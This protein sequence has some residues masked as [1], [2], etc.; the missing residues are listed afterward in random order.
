[1][2]WPFTLTESALEW[3]VQLLWGVDSALRCPHVSGTSCYFMATCHCPG[4]G[5]RWLKSRGP[6][7]EPCNKRVRSGPGW[8]KTGM[9]LRGLLEDACCSQWAR[10][11]DC[12]RW[13]GNTGGVSR[14]TRWAPRGCQGA[15]LSKCVLSVQMPWGCLD[16]G[17]GKLK[18]GE[19]QRQPID[20]TPSSLELV[21]SICFMGIRLTIH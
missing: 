9:S 16:W 20:P 13:S 12:A 14:S 6:K 5:V 3:E 8:K 1:M 15:S 2:H 11:R 10:V 17:M 18:Y 7:M 19:T 21:L 4:P